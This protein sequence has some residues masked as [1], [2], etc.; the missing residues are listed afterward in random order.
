MWDRLVLALHSVPFHVKDP[1]FGRDVS[2]YVF[3]LPF[4]QFLYGWAFAAL[5]VVTLVVAGA[6][7]V[8][9]GI[10]PQSAAE[11]VT[12]QVKAH[13]SVL[14]GLIAL[15]RAWGYRLGQYNLLYS[16][17]GKI[18]GASY[19]DLHAEL[20][21]GD[22]DTVGGLVFSLLGHVPTEGETV[23][24]N[25]HRLAAE[26]IQGRRIGR[27]RIAKLPRDPAEAADKPRD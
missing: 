21:A 25:G 5:V 22:W 16:T 27:V 18:S 1:V 14:I 13:L 2:F 11:R 10:R 8:T 6:H 24:A 19:T 23:E 15:L 26:K 9:G 7:Y 17:R 20:P 12:P 3:R 4:Y